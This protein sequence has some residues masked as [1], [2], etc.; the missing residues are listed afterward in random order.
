MQDPVIISGAPMRF[1]GILFRQPTLEQIY[2]DPDVGKAVYDSYLYLVS[3]DVEGFLQATGLTD[4]YMGL[5]RDIPVLDVN[6]ACAGFVFGLDMARMYLENG[7]RKVRYEIIT[8]AP[9][10]LVIDGVEK[11]VQA[12]EYVFFTDEKGSCL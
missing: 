1:G 8:P 4:V 11:E 5:A 2:R 10:T 12:G 9:A 7:C 6:A 3:L